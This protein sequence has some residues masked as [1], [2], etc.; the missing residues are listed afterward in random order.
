M[1]G[2][3]VRWTWRSIFSA[4]PNQLFVIFILHAFMVSMN[5]FENEISAVELRNS[6]KMNPKHVLFNK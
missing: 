4:R 3:Y 5:L 1:G 6:I 2:Q